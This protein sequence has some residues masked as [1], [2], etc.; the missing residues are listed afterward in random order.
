EG[1]WTMTMSP[2]PS[3]RGRFPEWAR[4]RTYVVTFKQSGADLVTIVSGPTVG[5]PY[6]TSSARLNGPDIVFGIS[7]DTQYNG[8]ASGALYD[9]W[10]DTEF[11]NVWGGI[12]GTISGSEID[13]TMEGEINYWGPGSNIITGPTVVCNAKDHVITLRR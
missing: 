13:A 4:T 1:D 5:T 3:C 9:R 7:G 10:S 11:L 2:S 6:P 12:T 8:W